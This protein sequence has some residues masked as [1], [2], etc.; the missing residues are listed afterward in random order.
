MRDALSPS[1]TFTSPLTMK[2]KLSTKFVKL[3][4][5]GNLNNANCQSVPDGLAV[6]SLRNQSS[7]TTVRVWRCNC[8]L[9]NNDEQEADC[10]WAR[11]NLS[12]SFLCVP[13]WF[14]WGEWGVSVGWVKG[15]DYPS[16]PL[17]LSLQRLSQRFEWGVR[18]S[19]AIVNQNQET[20][21]TVRPHVYLWIR[22]TYF[23][24]RAIYFP[25]SGT[26]LR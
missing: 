6:R 18:G 8:S 26:Y 23:W 14:R 21:Q 15:Q 12:V 5:T 22:H 3:Q 20:S 25:I 16:L 9:R 2:Y 11:S 19:H 4:L 24:I 1:L 13:C 7:L 17:S 10:L